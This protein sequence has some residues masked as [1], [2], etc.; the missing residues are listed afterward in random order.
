ME[1]QSNWE[2]GTDPLLSTFRAALNVQVEE[3]EKMELEN[4]TA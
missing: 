3:Q 2:R 1:V 4:E